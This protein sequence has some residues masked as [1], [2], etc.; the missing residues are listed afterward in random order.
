MMNNQNNNGKGPKGPL[1]NGNQAGAKAKPAEKHFIGLHP[2]KISEAYCFGLEAQTYLNTEFKYLVEQGTDKFRLTMRE[3]H[4][5]PY[6]AFCRKHFNAAAI[7]G[8]L[9]GMEVMDVGG[10]AIRTS[11][12]LDNDNK[13]R[14]SKRVHSMLP[15]VDDNDRLRHKR[16]EHLLKVKDLEF[17]G[18]SYPPPNSCMCVASSEGCCNC[19]V[20][21]GGQTFSEKA[22]AFI[23]IDSAY[24]PGVL[25]GI[26][27]EQCRS[28]TNK[29]AYYAFHDYQ[30]SLDK[31][32][33]SYHTFDSES[34]VEFIEEG[35]LPIKVRSTV[36]G[37]P[38]PY[39]HQVISTAGEVWNRFNATFNKTIVYQ[40][41]RRLKQGA[42]DYVLVSSY[43]LA[44]D[45]KI[46]TRLQNHFVTSRIIEHV[47]NY[48]S[49]KAKIIYNGLKKYLF[50]SDIEVSVDDDFI[51]VDHNG[52]KFRADVDRIAFAVKSLAGKYANADA[53]RVYYQMVNQT[54]GS[55][56][57]SELME[58]KDAI[59]IALLW[60]SQATVG[61][62]DFLNT[63][64]AIADA[65]SA[66]KGHTLVD[67]R[68]NLVSI[69]WD[70]L[71]NILQE[72]VERF[73]SYGW[74]IFRNLLILIAVFNLGYF[75]NFFGVSAQPMEIENEGV[76]YHGTTFNLM[77][78]VLAWFLVC[79][80]K[81][82]NPL[83]T[84][85]YHIPEIRWLR[86]NCVRDKNRLDME[87]NKGCFPAKWKF[88][89]PDWDIRGLNG[90]QAAHKLGCDKGDCIM[91]GQVGPIIRGSNLRTPTI[92]HPC[93]QTKMAA[94]IR[95][96]SNKLSPDPDMF[97]RWSNY[98]EKT[99]N[100]ILNFIELEGGLDVDID[101]WVTKYPERYQ[102]I[103]RAEMDKPEFLFRHEYL[104]DAFPKVE[105]Q[106]TTIFH[107]EKDLPFNTVKERQICGPNAQKKIA[108]NAFI[109][110]LE[111]LCHRNMKGYC[112]RKD[113][114]A[115]CGTIDFERMLIEDP[116]DGFGDMS[117]CDMSIKQCYNERCTKG[118][119]RVLNEGSVNL[120][121]RISK[122]DIVDAFTESHILK[123][124]VDRGSV[125]Y[126]VDGRASGDG[127]TAFM[128]TLVVRSLFNFMFD[129]LKIPQDQRA[130]LAKSDDTAVT[131]ARKYKELFDSNLYRYFSK[132][133]NLESHG[134]G[135]ILKF[136]KWGTMEDGD[137]LSNMFFN[138]G[139]HQTRMVR[140]PDRVFQTTP[141][142]TKVKP[143][144]KD[145]L[146]SC[147]ELCYSKGCCMLAWAKGLPIFEAYA[148]KLMELGKPGELS[149]YN[150]W[151]D[152]GR[153]WHDADDYSACSSW[154]NYRFGIT[155]EDIEE[156]ELAIASIE[157][158]YQ[159]V[160]IPCLD[161]FQ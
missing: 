97:N 59:S 161:K 123:V 79:L 4:P 11:V 145:L 6:A 27:V 73:K 77:I 25:E 37:N 72:L 146:S 117:G 158:I 92:I 49:D 50:D 147:Q 157:H 48:V 5:H 142:S 119:T 85:A 46:G 115:I 111:G 7:K 55:K 127:W 160:E 129:D 153:V 80:F 131:I 42:H 110:A 137:F 74:T 10:H 8:G 83:Q 152:G 82:T 65:R 16:W 102:E 132:A 116:V 108:A 26:E 30:M 90:E 32:I 98:F 125:Q 88:R 64:D 45:V 94:A 70:M 52:R 101:A 20:Q 84:I 122:K 75:L 36:R 138:T 118:M 58:I 69:N 28:K 41:E 124:N 3:P 144:M 23:S 149:D 63:S 139:Y 33:K 106:Y 60:N 61:L 1:A 135:F 39:S 151:S 109:Y 14:W 51:V 121:I 44:G 133:N 31:G 148:V 24:Y 150:K 12:S 56:S 113:W 91:G 140:I 15:I 107:D 47:A 96:C 100:E 155:A 154:M 67:R 54:N 143:G 130:L 13:T 19:L 112:G 68:P 104:Y 103:M 156:I 99:I 128:N 2:N 9:A 95:A 120:D 34:K 93:K 141:W 29:V 105:L 22:E 126:M 71:H 87:L 53:T 38:F 134:L 89:N 17:G 78:P 40:V 57:L 81:Y 86:S 114:P 21:P 76:D 159:E 66:A 18:Y 43:C 136:W 35:T 62:H